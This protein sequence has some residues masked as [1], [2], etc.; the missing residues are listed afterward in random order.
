M[1]NISRTVVKRTCF[2]CGSEFKDGFRLHYYTPVAPREYRVCKPCAE[3]AMLEKICAR[4]ATLA[5]GS[6]DNDKAGD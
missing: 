4:K 1:L 6:S 5:G 2:V 3:L